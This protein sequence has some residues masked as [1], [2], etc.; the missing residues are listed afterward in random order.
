MS[1]SSTLPLAWKA[2]VTEP[3][4]L[5]PTRARD[6]GNSRNVT[7]I[8]VL[9]FRWPDRFELFGHHLDRV[10]GAVG[11]L[12]LP[13]RC[14]GADRKELAVVWCRGYATSGVGDDGRAFGFA[15]PVTIHAGRPSCS[16]GFEQIGQFL[17]GRLQGQAWPSQSS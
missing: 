10:R 8:S 13:F 9:E 1:S 3:D 12:D 15:R 11:G 7:A 14:R 2:I 5:S 6:C 4:R 17:L 16:L